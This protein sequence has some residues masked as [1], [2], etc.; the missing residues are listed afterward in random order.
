LE[1][2]IALDKICSTMADIYKDKKIDLVVS[3]AIGGIL[4]SGGVGRYLNVKHIFSERLNGE[5]VFKRGFDIE[6]KQNILVVED[7]VTT[8]GSINE[9]INLIE[10]YKANIIGIVSIVDRNDKK[11]IFK[12]PYETLLNFPAESWDEK[13]C[14]NWLKKIPV[15][16]PGST[17]KK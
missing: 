4:I 15:F 17:G 11:K 7:I 13:D 8:G 3:A 16:K 14:P 5:M 1:N 10:K 12:Y 6:K 9:I 2:P